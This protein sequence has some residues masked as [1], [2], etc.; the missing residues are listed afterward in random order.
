M[1]RQALR[2]SFCLLRAGRHW[3]VQSLKWAY[4]LLRH[5]IHAQHLQRWTVLSFRLQHSCHG[6]HCPLHGSLA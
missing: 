4:P 1:R 6:F 5:P 2:G 3:H